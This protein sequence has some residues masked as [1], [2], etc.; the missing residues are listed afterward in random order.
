MP[1][2]SATAAVITAALLGALVAIGLHA[3]W[4]V[5]VESG[6]VIA[7]I[8]QLPADNPYAYYHQKAWSLLNQSSA[9][10]LRAGMSEIGASIVLAGLGG[11]LSFAACAATVCA[12][13]GHPLAAMLTPLLVYKLNLTGIGAVYPVY[14]LG[15]PHTYGVVGLGWSIAAAALAGGGWLRTGLFM[16]GLAPAIH[17]SVGSFC[18]ACILVA[19]YLDRTNRSDIHRTVILPLLAGVAGTLASLAAHLILTA[20]LPGFDTPDAG[21]YLSAFVENFDYHRSPLNF[22]RDGVI[23]AIATAVTAG[24]AI[25]LRDSRRPSI[26]LPAFVIATVAGSLVLGAAERAGISQRLTMLM[27]LRYLN[28]ANLLMTPVATG[29]LAR[30]S[31]SDAGPVSLL[32]LVICAVLSERL[33][34]QPLP[35]Y[36]A[37]MT[38]A[39]V[40]A[41][42]DRRGMIGKPPERLV[43]FAVF[44]AALAATISLARSV[45]IPATRATAAE[46]F[47]EDGR[48][49]DH[50]SDPILHE[51]SLRPGILLLAMDF[52]LIQIRVRR[53]VLLEG[54]ALDFFSY[55]PETGPVLNRMLNEIYGIDLF[56]PLPPGHRNR[57]VITNIHRPLWE[58]RPPQEWARLRAAYG[59]TDVLVPGDWRLRLPMLMNDGETAAYGIPESSGGGTP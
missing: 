41:L 58:A 45:V 22:Q 17:P 26:L 24:V 31:A 19:L 46:S 9:L 59:I 7:G 2:R 37:I 57:G 14:L 21:R 29:L 3:G 6:Q 51:L 4:Q 44:I 12:L 16:A 53:P 36:L 48:F 8:V 50:D 39:I 27:P 55:V 35:V 52:H 43:R 13:G 40:A 23:L 54:G 11:A 28:V 56:T 30:R 20:H 18:L 10:M 25:R 34:D 32:A 42:I 47:L 38:A 15:T 49:A 33:P 1:D 5:P